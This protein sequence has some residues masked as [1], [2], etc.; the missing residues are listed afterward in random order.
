MTARPVSRLL[1][2]LASGALLVGTAA[3]SASAAPWAADLAAGAASAAGGASV[4]AALA[5]AVARTPADG[6]VDVI[7]RLRGAT[8]PA[9]LVTGRGARERE[10]VDGL[11][12]RAAAS[13]AP[14]LALLRA[15]ALAGLVASATPLWIID[16]IAARV[17]PSVVAELAARP[18]VASVALD[19]VVTAPAAP[20]AATTTPVEPNV[21]LIGAPALWNLGFDG[22]GV[23]VAELDTGVDATHPDLA[24][25]YRGGTDSWFDPYGQ[26]PVTPYD[27]SGHGTWSM[28]LIVGGSAGGSSIGIAPGASWIAAKIYNDAGAG[29]LSGIHLAYQWALDPDGNPATPDAPTIVN[30]SWTLSTPGCSL[31]FEPDLAALV[32]AGITPVFAAGNFG[33]GSGTDASP[34]NNPDAFSVG[35]TDNTD[36]AASF[37][38]RG[39]TSCGRSAAATFPAVVA[40]GVAVT[41]TDLYGL[42][43]STSG[44][45]FSAPAVSGALALLASA[46]PALPAS[47]LRDALV[48][49][50]VDLGPAG[51][52]GTYGNGRIDVAAAYRSLAALPTPTPTPTATVAHTPTPTPTPTPTVAPTPTPTPTPTPAPDLTGPVVTAA[53]GAPSPSRGSA[54]IALSASATDLAGPGGPSLVAAAEWFEGTDPGPGNGTPMTAAD[55]R[56]DAGTE[57]LTGSVPTA[58]RSYGEHLVSI[59]A[60]DSAGNWG[61]ATGVVL[62]VTS[63]DGIF[64]DGFESGS[65]A[66]WTSTT[67]TTRLAVTGSAASGGAFG[68]AATIAGTGT[69]FVTDASPGAA[70]AYRARFTLATHGTVTGGAAVDVFDGL[71]AT[72]SIAFRLQL[73]RSN[74]GTPQVRLVATGPRATAT[75]SWVPITDAATSLEVVWTA[76]STARPVL[77]VNGVAASTLARLDTS[78]QRIAQ[79]RLGP[80]AGLAAGMAGTLYLDR[81]VSARTTPLGS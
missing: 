55:G 51:P 42:Y 43:T 41:T 50:A 1:V 59:R 79:V 24:P 66:S 76:S 47:Q 25:R 68:L 67:G 21:A 74:G 11:R 33:P 26:H 3:G 40:P 64:A 36:L 78:T 20:A 2:I 57:A 56:F 35:A 30:N 18:E 73:R 32:A 31:E 71:G 72:G 61:A 9:S 13:G 60:R 75:G 22:H 44:T 48:A 28:G 46:F 5:A 58:G 53:A 23:V 6:L 45:S 62:I 80:S 17:R 77:L 65:T 15:R 39:P 69:S 27:P 12:A 70:T 38:S 81:F 34:A 8:Q 4:D 63:A 7:I 16:G 54:A 29:T 52:D 49:T 37:S 10:V 19:Q 14:I